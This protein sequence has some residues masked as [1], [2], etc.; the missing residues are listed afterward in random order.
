MYI[1]HNVGYTR[2]CGT[3]K[4]QRVSIHYRRYRVHHT[5]G[6]IAGNINGPCHWVALVMKCY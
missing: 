3:N 1:E 5:T 4:W 2:K 6:V